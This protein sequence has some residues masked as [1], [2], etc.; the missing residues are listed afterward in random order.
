[1]DVYSREQFLNCLSG[2]WA[3]F[4]RRYSALSAADQRA[5]LEKQG[6]T[7][8]A[9]L[10]GH[11]IAWWQDGER[12]IEQMRR[13]PAVPLPQYDVDAFNAQAVQRFAGQ[14]EAEVACAFEAQRQKIENLLNDLSEAELT[15]PTIN[16]RLYYEVLSHWK[17]HALPQ[18]A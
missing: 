8:L 18:S 16:R 11:V 9:A 15:Y 13:N 6:Y 3:Q 17:E 2:E 14:S 5:Y 12:L 10:L 7:S 4:L 1:M